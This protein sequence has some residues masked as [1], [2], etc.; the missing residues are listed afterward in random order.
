MAQQIFV[1]SFRNGLVLV[2]ERMDWLESAAFTLAIPAGTI[3]DPGA[4][5]GLANF[6]CEMLLRGSGELDSRAYI[7]ALDRLGADRSAA[8]SAMHASFSASTLT[9]NLCPVLAIHADLVRR[10]HLPAEQ[11]ED[12]RLV[13]LQ[14]IQAIDDDLAQKTMIRLRKETY[15]EPW[16]RSSQGEVAMI[17]QVE[18]RDIAQFHRRYYS[19]VGAILSVAGKFDWDALRGATEQSFGDWAGDAIGSPPVAQTS[20]VN[21]HLPHDSSQTQI[22]VA[23]PTVPFRDTDYIQA[24][25]A[26]GVL[27]DGMSSRLFTHVR[28]ERGLCY[29]VYGYHHSL[30]DAAR[31]LCYA[32]T[33]TERAQETLDVLLA[34]LQRLSDGIEPEELVRLKARTKSAMIMQ[35]E[36]S[37][38]RAAS[39]VGDWYHLGRIR[40]LQEIHQLIDALTCETVGR[41]LADHPPGNYTVVTLGK[42][43]LEVHVGVSEASLG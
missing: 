31:V 26:V 43:P 38:A 30:R 28:E 12:G 17:E 16:G 37:A 8:V 33:S 14:E 24:R 19:P 27:S 18:L 4:Q 36:S 10:P 32:G 42:D 15:G 29:S 21:V 39:L 40:T 9:E 23:Y 2:A 41:F 25:A 3:H 13:C 35:Q 1:E 22:G 7:A 20:S 11:L 5:L 6:T 34:E